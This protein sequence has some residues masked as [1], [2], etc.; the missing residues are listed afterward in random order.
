MK[1]QLKS[2]HK[3]KQKHSI[4]SKED[5][6]RGKFGENTD[7]T[8]K[9][10]MIKWQLLDQDNKIKSNKNSKGENKIKI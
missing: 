6:N 10:Q 3:N 4:N 8:K 2:V 7:R 1:Q 9:K 5:I